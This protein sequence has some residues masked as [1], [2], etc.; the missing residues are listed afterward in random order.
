M[1]TNNRPLLQSL[2]YCTGSTYENI[3]F[4]LCGVYTARDKRVKLLRVGFLGLSWDFPASYNN[5]I[6]WQLNGLTSPMFLCGDVNQL[7]EIIRTV[8]SDR[9]CDS[10]TNSYG[11]IIVD[12]G[13]LD[14][15]I[16]VRTP[17]GSRQKI[18]ASPG[19]T[20]NVCKKNSVDSGSYNYTVKVITTPRITN[21]VAT[22]REQRY[23]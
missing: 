15:P 9:L 7:D 2:E 1:I 11:W 4:S 8:P 10:F 22:F 20:I 13:D 5:Q 12:T 23:K 21:H 14:S 18:V 3:D 19:V 6:Y 16:E 17:C